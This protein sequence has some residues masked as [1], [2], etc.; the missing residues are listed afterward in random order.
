[1]DWFFGGIRKSLG[2]AKTSASSRN[3]NRWGVG[4]RKVR[5]GGKSACRLEGIGVALLLAVRCTRLMAAIVAQAC[6]F[7]C[8]SM[9]DA[10]LLGTAIDALKHWTSLAERR[11]VQCA[12]KCLEGM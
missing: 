8:F 4:V 3:S 1:M 5:F 7:L 10:D 11:A 9:V 6:R 2:M 12:V